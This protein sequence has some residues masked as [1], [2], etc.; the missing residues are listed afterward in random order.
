VYYRHT[1][2]AVDDSNAWGRG[3]LLR[4]KHRQNCIFLGIVEGSAENMIT[5]VV[6][7]RL[8]VVLQTSCVNQI[9]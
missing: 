3:V 8:S 5:W 9:V 2:W 1:W 4:I 7:G 6:F